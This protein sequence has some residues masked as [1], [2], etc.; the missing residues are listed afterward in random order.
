MSAVYCSLCIYLCT[1][2]CSSARAKFVLSKNNGDFCEKLSF[3]NIQKNDFKPLNI[4]SYL[5]SNS[6]LTYNQGYL[7]NYAYNSGN[8]IK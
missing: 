3:S 8:I 7:R 4:L 2:K 1:E 5:Q 6:N